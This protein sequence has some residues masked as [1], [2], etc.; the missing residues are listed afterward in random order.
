MIVVLVITL[1]FIKFSFSEVLWIPYLFT[2]VLVL[3]S[4]VT[5]LDAI[6]S[7][8]K[9]KIS[10]DTFNAFALGASFLLGSS[11]STAFIVLMLASAR[12]LDWHTQSRASRAMEEI[13]KL[14]PLNA[15]VERGGIVEIVEVSSLAVGEVMVIMNGARVPA[16]GVVVMGE[17]YINEASISGESRL[18][19]KVLGSEVMGGTLNE[20]GMI[21]VRATRVGRDST[22]ERVAILIK[23]A[24]ENKSRSEKTGDRFAQIFLPIVLVMGIG[25]YLVTHN[26]AMVVALFLIACA[27]DV[28]VSIPLAM[29]AAIGQAAKRGVIIK[30]GMYLE[31]L[32]KIDTLVIDKTGTLTYGELRVVNVLIE[33]V[34]KDQFW[35]LLGMVE[36]F[37]EH[38]IARAVVEEAKGNIKTIPDPVDFKEHKGSGVVA[39]C[40]DGEIAVGDESLF[41]E[42]GLT[43][44]ERVRNLLKKEREVFGATSFIVYINRMFAGIISVRDKPK[45]EA[46]KSIQK[47]KDLGLKRIIMFTGDDEHTALSVAAAIGITEVR[48]SMKPEDKLRELELL[49]KDNQVAMVGDGVND[50]PAL[51]R[52]H[53]GIAMGGAG[54]AV[55]VEAADIIILSDDLARIPEMILLSRRVVRVV[56]GDMVIW[57]ITNLI[58]FGLVF[59]Q[60]IGPAMA[61][62]YNFATDFLPLINS[63]RLF[64]RK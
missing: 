49:T 57:V 61:A 62:F 33:G 3:A 51:A 10:I 48:A 25:T 44:D 41:T 7:A 24:S 59:V 13:L 46:K 17:A 55:A 20:S 28:A 63:A 8:F 50:A 15:S 54:S 23:E 16:D 18:I 2:V 29:T 26:I 9:L 35:S 12:L 60:F 37:S 27:D 22:L 31:A 4:V 56:R 53:V 1:L 40:E 64:K 47:L 36:K 32:A 34:T 6:K 38:P 11:D 39:H 45:R 52:A 14:K 21:K 58:G 43:V 30:G 19:I 42:L 5:F